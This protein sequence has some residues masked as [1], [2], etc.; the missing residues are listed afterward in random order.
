MSR[1]WKVALA[2][3]LF[4]II[5]S[6]PAW[7]GVA[8]MPGE[9]TD[10]DGLSGLFTVPD[11]AGSQGPTLFED[12]QGKQYALYTDVGRTD[13]GNKTAAVIYFP[14][15][16]LGALFVRLAVGLT[17]WLN[18]L[19]QTDIGITE[20]GTGLQSATSEL[21]T[22][23]LPA[24]LAIGMVVAYARSRN[25]QEALSQ[26]M[27]TVGLGIAA[28]AVAT[29]GAQMLDTVDDARQL[30][31]TTAAKAGTDAV[32]GSDVPFEW[33]GEDLNSG[34]ESADVTRASGDAVWRSFA[35]VPW[36]QAQFGSQEACERYGADWL[37][38]NGDEER[39][40]Y[41][42][43]VIQKQEGGEDA[44]TVKFVKGES[45]GERI[46]IAFFALLNG[47]GVLFVVGGLA[48]LALMPWVTA[49]LLAYLSS[50]FLCALAIPGRV[51]QIG[52]DFLN[53]LGGLTLLSAL[54]TGVL[55]GALMAVNA[56]TSVAP[57]Q[58]W[59][60][61]AILTTAV[62]LA[63][64]QARSLLERILFVS[65]AGSGRGGMMA[66]M[67]GLAAT[68]RI[69]GGARSLIRGN[70][71]GG[72]QGKSGTGQGG[73][74]GRF[75]RSAGGPGETGGR[76]GARFFPGRTER[77]P[78]PGAG[79]RTGPRGTG[80]GRNERDPQQSADTTGTRH[81]RE[82]TG[83][84]E[85]GGTETGAHEPAHARGGFYDR[86]RRA[87]RTGDQARARERLQ[88]REQGQGKPAPDSYRSRF[89]E[90]TP[91]SAHSNPRLSEQAQKRVNERRR[92][93]RSYDKA[94]RQPA[95]ARQDRGRDPKPQQRPRRRFS[96][97]R[98]RQ[99][100]QD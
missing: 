38:L 33:E 50:V 32:T 79:S 80:H 14:L 87:H 99:E 17:W 19:T 11:L 34:D 53:M 56:V 25:G 70:K 1:R 23:L 35:V 10:P 93:A 43:K 31:S 98:R 27:W 91:K 71:G 59:L 77:T 15:Q 74:G 51:R 100:G 49:V 7:A 64:W 41:I 30:L 3:L 55:T 97:E 28:V 12:V 63:A 52:L 16:Q 65:A 58:G 72:G 83:S 68:K 54:T 44:A 47:V 24:A 96:R 45:G 29:S 81:G 57:V 37:E 39:K 21:N 46:V 26:V 85:R 90:P 5:G 6:G 9:P 69:V 84:G 73:S 66:A 89:T 2:A 20:L 8:A 18:T 4:Y 88:R 36:C 48:L 92:Q 13:I 61:S 62:L 75:G 40:D 94:D 86:A 82:Y 76:R 60:P 42:E 67:M 95:A 22:W 78:R